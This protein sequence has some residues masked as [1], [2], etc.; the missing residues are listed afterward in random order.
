MLQ[1]DEEDKRQLREDEADFNTLP[2]CKID[3]A[4]TKEA[5]DWAQ[6]VAE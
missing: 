5:K 1:A 3:E 2:K 6:T 4:S